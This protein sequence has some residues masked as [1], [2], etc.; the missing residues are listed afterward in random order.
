MGYNFPSDDGR[1]RL[2]GTGREESTPSVNASFARAG[3]QAPSCAAD[4]PSTHPQSLW[5]DSP[6]P[7]AVVYGRCGLVARQS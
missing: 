7:G 6:T 1:R 2:D 3:Q 4:M 5:P